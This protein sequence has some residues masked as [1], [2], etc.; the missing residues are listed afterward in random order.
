MF[1]QISAIVPVPEGV[2]TDCHLSEG[3]VR[4]DDTSFTIGSPGLHMC[5]EDRPIQEGSVNL[6]KEKDSAQWGE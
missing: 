2:D 6:L 1:L 4:L 3:G 5:T